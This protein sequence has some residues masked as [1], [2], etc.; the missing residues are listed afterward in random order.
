MIWHD[1]QASSSLKDLESAWRASEDALSLIESPYVGDGRPGESVMRLQI[2][3]Q[4]GTL[5][6]L[7][8]ADPRP[9]GV[10]GWARRATGSRRSPRS[11]GA[12]PRGGARLLSVFP[13]IS[14]LSHIFENRESEK[15][16]FSSAMSGARSSIINASRSAPRVWRSI[17]RSAHRPQA[18]CLQFLHRSQPWWPSRPF[19]CRS[20][21]YAPP[22]RS[23][24]RRRCAPDDHLVVGQGVIFSFWKD[25]PLH[26]VSFSILEAQALRSVFIFSVMISRALFLIVQCPQ[27]IL[28]LCSHL[29]CTVRKVVLSISFPCITM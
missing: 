2:L 24:S 4:F 16:F 19:F 25:S 22:G 27:S 29:V 28:K 1:H 11:A 26:Q 10:K 23:L 9:H 13:K 7:C 21:L 8:A 15:S 20:R 6:A 14:I 18:S 3:T 17:H 12:P 5:S